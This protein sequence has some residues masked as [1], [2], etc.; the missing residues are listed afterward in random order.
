MS[1]ARVYSRIDFTNIKPEQVQRLVKELYLDQQNEQREPCFAQTADR[2][3][4]DRRRQR[5]NVLL[6]TR[7]S[8]SRRQSSGRRSRDENPDN[9]H[10]VGIDYYA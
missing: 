2:R 8:Q 4:S 3:R 10:K 1:K 9:N 7:A 5:Q 6:D